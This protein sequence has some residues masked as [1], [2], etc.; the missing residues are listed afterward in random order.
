MSSAIRIEG[1]MT[2][3]PFTADPEALRPR[4]RETKQRFDRLGTV[5]FGPRE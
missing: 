5:L 4:F 1:L 3:G 2:M